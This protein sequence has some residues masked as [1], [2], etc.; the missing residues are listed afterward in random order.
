MPPRRPG[1]EVL[2]QCRNVGA[3]F[4]L[5]IPLQ[6]QLGAT[7]KTAMTA[8]GISIFNKK[9]K[10]KQHNHVLRCHTLS[11]KFFVASSSESAT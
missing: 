5:A 1:S 8:D 9:K 6:E 11:L 2:P 10:L 7:N 3:V 4:G